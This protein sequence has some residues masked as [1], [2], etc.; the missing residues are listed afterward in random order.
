MTLTLTPEEYQDYQSLPKDLSMKGVTGF[1]N[2]KIMDLKSYYENALF[3][4]EGFTAV[5]NASEE[6][7]SLTLKRDQAFMDNIL[8]AWDS[9]S[10]VLIT[11]G[12]QADSKTKK[13]ADELNLPII[14]S[15]EDTYN[16]AK[17]INRAIYDQL[18]KKDILLVEDIAEEVSEEN[19]LFKTDL[20]SKWHDRNIETKHKRF[21][22]VDEQMRLVGI[23]TSSDILGQP[24]D[25]KI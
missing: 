17:I 14:V 5:L 11:G 2:K 21:P 12:F 8:K 25:E 13:M 3:L 20:V 4:E 6:F 18:I 15:K 1:L 24:F 7:Y 22:V 9:K 16:V 23:A 10:A 19:S